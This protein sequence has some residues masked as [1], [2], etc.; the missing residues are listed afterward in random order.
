MTKKDIKYRQ[1]RSKR[2]QRANEA[3]AHYAVMGSIIV[4]A[5]VI[6]YNIFTQGIPKY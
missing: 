2:Q 6:I 1:G 3:I 5:L 4:I